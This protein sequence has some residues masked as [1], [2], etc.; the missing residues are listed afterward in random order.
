MYS[1][2][3]YRESQKVK[4][5][6]LLDDLHTSL[7]SCIDKWAQQEKVDSQVLMEWYNKVIEDA[8]KAVARLSMKSKKTKK[9]TLKSPTISKILKDLQKDFVFVPTDK[10]SNNIAVV[11]K[12]FYVEQSMKELDIFFNSSEKKPADKT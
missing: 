9:M 1:G 4:W 8:S 2:P 11:C 3:G 5:P 7:K 6:A 10:A 12:K